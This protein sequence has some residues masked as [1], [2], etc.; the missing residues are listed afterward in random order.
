MKPSKCLLTTHGMTLIS[1][2][3]RYEVPSCSEKDAVNID[4]LCA[5]TRFAIPVTNNDRPKYSQ[6]NDRPSPDLIVD[7]HIPYS[8]KG[9]LHKNWIGVCEPLVKTLTLFETKMCDFPYSTYNMSKT[10]TP[11]LRLDH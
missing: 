2:G 11:F 9:L 3:K 10:W 7:N 1:L 5:S 4:C 6:L 8:P